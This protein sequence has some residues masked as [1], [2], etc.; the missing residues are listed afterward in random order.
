MNLEYLT[1]GLLDGPLIRLYHFTAVEAALLLSAVTDLASGAAEKIDVDRLP[2]VE[3][4]GSC[5]LALVSWPWD[6]AITRENEPAGFVCKLTHASWDNVAGL[7]EPFAS[8]S[9]GFQWLVGASG[10]AAL[11]LSSSGHW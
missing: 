1:D 9:V 3:P 4:V 8:G 11:L 5:R 2:Y 6:Q 10:E 7:V